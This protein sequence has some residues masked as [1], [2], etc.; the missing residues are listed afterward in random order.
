MCQK[1]KACK[2]LGN[3]HGYNLQNLINIGIFKT[4][5]VTPMHVGTKKLH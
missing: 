3:I 1:K 2:L 5:E 4:I